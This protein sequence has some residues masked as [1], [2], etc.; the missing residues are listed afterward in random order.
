MRLIPVMQQTL[1]ALHQPTT[2]LRS[3]VNPS[4]AADLERAG[5]MS[6]MDKALSRA[7]ASI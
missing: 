2:W 5:N 6:V 3:I 7:H 4:Y 1:K